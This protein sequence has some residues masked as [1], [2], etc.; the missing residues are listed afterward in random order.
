MEEWKEYKLGEVLTIKYGKDHK[1]LADGD[2][3]IYGS[4][5]IMRYGDR[6]L[7]DGPSILIPRKGSLNNVIYADKPFWTV[8]TMFWSIINDSI[9][10]PLFVYY[11][12]CKKDFASL[13]V[14]SAV[15]SLTVPVIE[16]IDILLPSKATQDKVISVLKS[17]DDKIEVNR[18]IND[19]LEQQAQALF[20]S[21][22]VDFEPFKDRKFVNS[23]LGMIPEGWRVG[24]LNELIISTLGGDW[25]KEDAIGNY[26]KKVSCIRGADIPEI[27]QGNRGNMPTRFILNKN[28]LN[29]ALKAEDLVVEISGGSPTQST[30]RICQISDTLLKKYDDVV[31][32]TNF[33]RAIKTKRPYSQFIYYLWEY[34]YKRGVMFLYEN[35]TTG[36]KNLDINGLLE[37][38]IIVIPDENT[39]HKYTGICNLFSQIVQSNGY[40]SER[41]VRLRDTLLPKLM[42]GELEINDIN[43]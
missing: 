13:N 38:E 35:G 12:I 40:E 19:N 27:R 15:P 36:I 23:E 3:P 41:L 10:N 39:V 25:G 14:G 24:T 42:S 20:K 30:G 8:D 32:C 1:Q 28:F 9:A 33:C 31:I 11:S 17:L 7:Y 43:N 34:L 16:D 29:K 21:W 2:R 5:G 18:R 22:F 6:S 4:G 26:V 37:K